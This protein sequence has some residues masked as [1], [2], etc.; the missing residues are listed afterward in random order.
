MMVAKQHFGLVAVPTEVF[1]SNANP[2]TAM[3]TSKAES[4]GDGNAANTFH[5][6][7]SQLRK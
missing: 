7:A 3:A 2:K 4:L 1:T 5:E 6:M